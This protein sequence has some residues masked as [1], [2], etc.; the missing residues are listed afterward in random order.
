MI[1]QEEFDSLKDGDLVEVCFELFGS[2]YQ[3][4]GT[5]EPIHNPCHKVP[6]IIGQHYITAVVPLRLNGAPVNG[7]TLSSGAFDRVAAFLPPGTTRQ[8][9]AGWD[10]ERRCI[11]SIHPRSSLVA[12]RKEITPPLPCFECKQFYPMAEN[13]FEGDKLVCFSCVSSNGWKYGRNK[14][15]TVFRK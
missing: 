13:N 8:H 15:R 2:M 9:V 14:D 10:I 6:V 3:I 11:G 7:W 12:A 5:W 1:S 4:H